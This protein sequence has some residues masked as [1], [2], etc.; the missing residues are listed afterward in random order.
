MR[1]I[2]NILLGLVALTIGLSTAEAQNNKLQKRQKSSADTTW[3]SIGPGNFS[4][5]VLV[6]HVDNR[7]AKKI[8][9]G[10]AGGGLW[11]S[12]NNGVSWNRCPFFPG[13]AAVSSITQD[14]D[15][16]IYIGTGEFFGLTA[17]G[18]KTNIGDYGIP[19]D[20]IYTT[21]DDINFTFIPNSD[22]YEVI[23]EMV[24]NSADNSIYI[25]TEN[26]LKVYSLTQK[27]IQNVGTDMKGVADISIGSDGTIIYSNVDI[28]TGIA[29]VFLRK[30]SSTSFTSVCGTA[31]TRIP[32]NAG[33]ISVA[34]APSDPDII[35]AYAT[36]NNSAATPNKGHYMGVYKSVDKGTTWTQIGKPGSYSGPTGNPEKSAGFGYYSNIIAV[37]PTSSSKVFV[38]TSFLYEGDEITLQNGEKMYSFMPVIGGRFYSANYTHNGFYLGTSNRL[39]RST[40]DGKTILPLNRYLNN[41]QVYSFSVGNKGEILLSARDNGNIYIKNSINAESE[42]TLLTSV[43]F[44]QGINNALSMIKSEAIFYAD[45]TGSIYR[46]ASIDSD[47]QKPESWYGSFLQL[48]KVVGVTSSVAKELPHWYRSSVVAYNHSGLPADAAYYYQDNVSPIIFWE[49]INDRN[50]ID[51]ITYVADRSYPPGDTITVRS[52]ANGYPV[53]IVYSTTDTLFK[54]STV[55]VQDIVTSRFFMG[56]GSYIE[57]QARVGAP[58]FVSNN[59]LDFNSTQGEYWSCVF[60]THDLTEQVIEL[61]VSK[62]GNDLFILTKKQ[63]SDIMTNYSI[64]RVSGFDTYR[65]KEDI[66]VASI[67][68]GVDVGVEI[69][70][71]Q[72]KLINDTLIYESQ[73][74]G[75]LILGD[76]LSISLDPQ[77]KENLLYTTNEGRRVNLIT[78]AATGT[79]STVTEANKDGAGLPS[80]SPVYTGIIEM[81]Q[82]NVA[83]VGTGEGVYKTESFNSTNPVWT[84]YN[85]GIDA[86]V[87]VFKLLQQTNEIYDD[88]CIYYNRLG[89]AITVFFPG[90][91]NTGIIY[92]ATHGLGM[93]AYKEYHRP[94]PVSVPRMKP[95]AH[96]NGLK[97]YPNP[98]TDMVTVD[99]TLAKDEQIQLNIVDITGKT[100]FSN[101]MGN[102][103]A[104]FHSEMINCSNLPSGMYF[105]TLKTKTQNKTAKIVVTK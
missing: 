94:H 31:A 72:R 58:V 66:E 67:A 15:G 70:N 28:A 11:I 77:N 60:R 92:A 81:T 36:T 40:D 80:G 85:K 53:K 44:N 14:P 69:D 101:N 100:I 88:S 99:F 57:S 91:Y 95:M 29:D 12:E 83:F 78:N 64:Y 6:T 96:N 16:L 33:R 8:Y 7:N 63:N 49:S 55:S 61:Q 93:F 54:D 89:E 19:G 37:S 74:S 5:R 79:R 20:G 87:P 27:T 105:V 13:S 59:V 65:K 25:G 35:Y 47:V 98:A 22:D 68:L 51:T 62:D 71:P 2:R 46:M 84:S 102:R 45:V 4:G 76:I 3:V 32:N 82:P 23:K 34:I 50:S 86:N 21:E 103:D 18:V 9:V 75:R 90:V 39:Y 30:P 24:Y 1:T 73:V 52:N 26:G 104:G 17:P 48:R 43:Y 97:V 56:G 41:L 38:G 10:T 42:G